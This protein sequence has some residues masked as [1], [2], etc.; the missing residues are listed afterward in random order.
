MVTK[1][2]E[3]CICTNGFAVM[4]ATKISPYY[5]LH[6]FN[7][8]DFLKQILKYKYGTAIPCIGR[9]D[10]ENILVPIPTD[11]EISKIE[12]RIKKAIQLRDEALRLLQI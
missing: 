5:L 4:K 7:S 12:E 10:F 6:F 8:E 9:E 1:N 3:G 2:F 11:R